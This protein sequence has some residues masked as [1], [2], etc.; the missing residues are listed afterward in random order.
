MVGSWWRDKEVTR[1]ENCSAVPLG[2][3]QGDYR[4]DDLTSA[5]IDWL[6]IL[7]LGGTETAIW[8]G[9][10]AQLADVG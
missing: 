6:K 2:E 10:K 8:L 1:E 5:D 4:A 7:F 3:G 9:I